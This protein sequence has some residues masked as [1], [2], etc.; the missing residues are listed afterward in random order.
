MSRMVH[1][2][3]SLCA[4]QPLGNLFDK[5]ELEP[6]PATRPAWLEPRAATRPAW[7]EPAGLVRA[8]QDA[9]VLK[10]DV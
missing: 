7:P 2:G 8:S 10:T 1:C 9:D 6:R 5:A 3:P 4:R